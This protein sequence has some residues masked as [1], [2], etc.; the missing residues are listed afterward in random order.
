MELLIWIIVSLICACFWGFITSLISESKGYDSGFWW[1][2]WLGIIGLIVVAFKPTNYDSL[3]DEE[4]DDIEFDDWT[5]PNCRQLNDG[6]ASE[7]M[8]CELP[9]PEKTIKA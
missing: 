9:R 4:T 8:R 5:C 1:G 7:C 2:F 3:K 6:F